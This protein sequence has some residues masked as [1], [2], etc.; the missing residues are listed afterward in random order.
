[1]NEFMSRALNLTRLVFV[2]APLI[3]QSLYIHSVDFGAWL[4]KLIAIYSVMGAIAFF[5]IP[6]QLY[7][8]M[9]LGPFRW[10]FERFYPEI[11]NSCSHSAGSEFGPKLLLGGLKVNELA[12]AR[13]RIRWHGT[14]R[15]LCID[16]DGWG[17]T[18]DEN[19]AATVLLQHVFIKDK[20]V[21]D[22]YTFRITDPSTDYHH[23]WLSFQ[24]INHLRFGGWL[25]AYRD[26]KAACPYKVIQ[27][28]SCPP[29]A[30]K[31][32]CA[33]TNMPPPSQRYCTGFYLSEQLS[34][35]RAYI[36]H[37]PDRHA[38]LLEFIVC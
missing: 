6:D 16:H 24:A 38:A 5:A 18:G 26:Q 28:S 19:F 32:L 13:C 33:M 35:S 15:Y 8:G 29:G 25:G 10:I 17:V 7:L 23:N 27:D 9:G 11:I 4:A 2:A 31:L 12:G 3:I 34:G 37:A 1:M 21:P 22:T 36:G 30:C 20:K 14:G